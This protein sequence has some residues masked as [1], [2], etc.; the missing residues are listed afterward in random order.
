MILHGDLTQLRNLFA[1]DNEITAFMDD[2]S[3]NESALKSECERSML[4]SA[5]M[6][7]QSLK[8]RP[9]RDAVQ[10]DT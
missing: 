10:K 1:T 5:S 3:Q 4:T 2:V 9:G 6:K 7:T 8:L